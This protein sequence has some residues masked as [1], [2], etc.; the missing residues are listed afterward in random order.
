[1]TGHIFQA[2]P[3]WIYTQGSCLLF[4]SQTADLFHSMLVRKCL[5][6]KAA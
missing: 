6:T 1:V 3:V 5:R 2:R 4:L